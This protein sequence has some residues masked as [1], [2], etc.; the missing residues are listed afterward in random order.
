MLVS[1]SK[2]SPQ[3]IESLLVFL[4]A[5]SAL[6][7]LE[8]TRA[9]P[10]TFECGADIG[11]LEPRQASY[12]FIPDSHFLQSF[13]SVPDSRRGYCNIYMLEIITHESLPIVTCHA[14]TAPPVVTCSSNVY[15]SIWH[16]PTCL[17]F[18][19]VHEF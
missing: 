3:R 18:F 11:I 5:K 7:I 8:V 10:S 16:P 17:F 19:F 4:K 9:E 14:I 12:E 15:L 13:W 6:T 1:A 2:K